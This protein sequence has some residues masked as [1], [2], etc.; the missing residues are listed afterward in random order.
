MK[1]ILLLFAFVL[2]STL[3]YSQELT[4]SKN[5]NGDTVAKDKYGNIVATGSKNYNGDFVWKDKYGNV[6]KTESRNYNGDKVS[7][8]NYGK[9]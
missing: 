8:D 4:Y 9:I 5:Y 7:K 6:I 1:K 2:L 3:S